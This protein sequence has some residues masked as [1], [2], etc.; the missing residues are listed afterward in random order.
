MSSG[1]IPNNQ[2]SNISLG[3][4][5]S[6]WNSIWAQRTST[7]DII[8]KYFDVKGDVKTYA[9]EF[10]D[11]ISRLPGVED[12]FQA[13]GLYNQLRKGKHK[14]FLETA[15]KYNTSVL[16]AYTSSSDTG[17]YRSG[18]ASAPSI[19]FPISVDNSDSDKLTIE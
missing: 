5:S 11:L 7:D 2:I 10:V 16:P 14:E 9:S 3:N 15:K 19:S 4:S 6:Q 17:I 18:S 13:I 1:I 8:R 12:N